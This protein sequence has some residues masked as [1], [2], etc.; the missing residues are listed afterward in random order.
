MDYV[1]YANCDRVL[2]GPLL[3]FERT[4]HFPYSPLP[5]R[6]ALSSRRLNC[7][8]IRHGGMRKRTRRGGLVER[9]RFASPKV[10]M[11]KSPKALQ[12]SARRVANETALRSL[13]IIEL[14]L[15]ARV[16]AGQR[17]ARSG[18]SGGQARETIVG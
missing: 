3:G 12:M 2:S 18:C 1:R 9:G 15:V 5:K 13:R 6:R 7:S 17:S 10:L 4:H 8:A 14:R 11:V 16:C